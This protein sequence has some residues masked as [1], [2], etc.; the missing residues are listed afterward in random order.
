VGGLNRWTVDD[1]LIA[2]SGPNVA[3][4]RTV[5]PVTV[6]SPVIPVAAYPW[7]VQRY[8]QVPGL[9]NATVESALPGNWHKQ[10]IVDDERHRNTGRMG[11][12]RFRKTFSFGPFFRFNINKRSVGISGGVPGARISINTDGRRTRSVGVPGTGLYY[13]DQTAPSHSQA[14]GGNESDSLHDPSF[15]AQAALRAERDYWKGVSDSLNDESRTVED[16]VEIAKGALSNEDVAEIEDLSDDEALI[17]VGAEA[18]ALKRRDPQTYKRM[19]KSLPAEERHQIL[20]AV[21]VAEARS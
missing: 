12:F 9:V 11:S 2:S 1:D 8:S 17:A 16:R 7:T 15:A 5:Y 14:K 21:A 20:D 19:L 18:L 3:A 10:V 6:R 13:R 4:L